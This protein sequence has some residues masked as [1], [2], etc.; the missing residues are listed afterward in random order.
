[1]V[2]CSLLVGLCVDVC[3]APERTPQPP[4]T[5]SVSAGAEVRERDDSGKVWSWP[6]GG[7]TDFE[8]S[9]DE[10]DGPG[11]EA[12]AISASSSSSSSAQQQRRQVETQPFPPEALSAARLGA[13]MQAAQGAPL[14]PRAAAAASV[15]G[16][17]NSGTGSGAVP[18][19]PGSSKKA[20]SG[21]SS[22]RAGGSAGSAAG[23]VHVYCFGLEGANL[24]EIA[25]S[26]GVSGSLVLADR[27][28]DADAVLA[29]RSKIKTSEWLGGWVVGRS[30]AAVLL[31][32]LDAAN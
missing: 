22:S 10:E 11:G 12:G 17:T 1:M 6:E 30:V 8:D 24:A 31:L 26:L 16:G 15:F 21:G 13:A 4:Q 14:A 5:S 20:G 23:A 18:A 32:L 7:S 9:S 2:K 29:L 27:L 25:Q 3:I 19:K 28:Q